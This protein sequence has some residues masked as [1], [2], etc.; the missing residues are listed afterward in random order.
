MLDQLSMGVAQFDGE[1]RLTYTNLPFRRL[2][3]L[4]ADIGDGSEAGEVAFK[5]FLA[6]AR[7]KGRTPEVRD[8][9]EWRRERLGWFEGAADGSG[10]RDENW[11]LPGGTHLRVVAQPMPDGGLV[12]IAEDRT[13]SLSLSSSKDTLLRTR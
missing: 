9:P 6:E 1:E 8:F 4:G 13:E 2:F 11:P 12:M 3:E 7:E 5:R 10:A